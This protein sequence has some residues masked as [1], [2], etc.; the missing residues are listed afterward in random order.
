MI[1]LALVERNDFTVVLYPNAALPDLMT[2]WRR[3]LIDSTVFFDFFAAGAISFLCGAV[4][5][6]LCVDRQ[7]EPQCSPHKTT[8]AVSLRDNNFQL[9]KL[10]LGE[11]MEN[12]AA[13]M[14]GVTGHDSYSETEAESVQRTSTETAQQLRELHSQLLQVEE[15]IRSDPTNEQYLQTRDDLFNVIS[16]TEDLIEVQNNDQLQ[17][18]SA[19]LTSAGASGSNPHWASENFQIGDH[20]EV[21]SG[22]RPY[23]AVLLSVNLP[24]SQCT[25][26][27]YEYGTEVTL[28]LSEVRVITGKGELKAE[29]V[30][31]GLRCQCKYPPDQ[32]W[33]DA[34]IEAV[35]PEA[36]VGGSGC[37]YTVVFTQYGSTLELPLEY[38][39]RMRLSSSKLTKRL[40]ERHMEPAVVIPDNLK[41]N[42]TDT[43]AVSCPLSVSLVTPSSVYFSPSL[44]LSL[45]AAKGEEE[46]E[47]QGHQEQGPAGGQGAGAVRHSRQL[48]GLSDQGAPSIPLSL[49]PSGGEEE[50]EA[51]HGALDEEAESVLVTGGGGRAGGGDRER[52]GHD[53]L[54]APEE[55]Q[56][57]PRQHL[58]PPP[59]LSLSSEPRPVL[60]ES[61]EESRHSLRSPSSLTERCD[62]VTCSSSAASCPSLHCCRCDWLSSASW[63]APPPPSPAPPSRTG[64][65]SVACGCGSAPCAPRRPTESTPAPSPKSGGTRWK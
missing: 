8:P 24:L 44:S 21:L 53:G 41:I 20:L 40:S 30:A 36:G 22:E 15:F 56:V 61:E 33:Y 62:G 11:Q 32:K 2:S 4:L 17:L 27:Y 31:P 65:G 16:M 46:A 10:F 23:P 59:P 50:S 12:G 28:S 51:R 29:E 54:R 43:E 13:S 55:I 60:R 64:T 38:L 58:T 9:F 49:T 45:R 19:T 7:S 18:S 6:R 25:L 48:E 5:W 14:A 47:G 57:Q 63:P 39:R 34:K 52:T 35:T 42:P 1:I 37:S 3:E 26:K